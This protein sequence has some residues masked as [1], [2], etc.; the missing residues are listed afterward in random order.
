MNA[1]KSI[2]KFPTNDI[3]DNEEQKVSGMS[4]EELKKMNNDSNNEF[5]G[6]IFD[7]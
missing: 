3:P 1:K 2:L 6:D 5:F 4:E 7:N